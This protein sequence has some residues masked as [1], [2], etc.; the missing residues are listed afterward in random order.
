MLHKIIDS[1]MIQLS[2][3]IKKN[4]ELGICS[5]KFKMEVGHMT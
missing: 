5:K 1:A 4:V 2:L 3:L